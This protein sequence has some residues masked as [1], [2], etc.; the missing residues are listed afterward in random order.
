MEEE[1]KTLLQVDGVSFAALP[2]ANAEMP[3]KW[4]RTLSFK[5]V[6]VLASPNDSERHSGDHQGNNVSCFFSWFW[7]L[8]YSL[9]FLFYFFRSPFFPFC[10]LIVRSPFFLPSGS[11]GNSQCPRNSQGPGFSDFLVS[12]VATFFLHAGPPI[13]TRSKMRLG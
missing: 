13:I 2:P 11:L 8:L 4:E 9:A 10:S 3:E 5:N 7:V 1:K 12:L 6:R